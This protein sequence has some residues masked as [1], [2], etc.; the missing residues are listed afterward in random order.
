MQTAQT[1]Q[2]E[3]T[4]QTKETNGAIY[5]RG[6]AQP[7]ALQDQNAAIFAQNWHEQDNRCTKKTNGQSR[8]ASKWPPLVTPWLQL[9]NILKV[10]STCR[11]FVI[12]TVNLFHFYQR[13]QMKQMDQIWKDTTGKLPQKDPNEPIWL[14][15]PQM[16]YKRAK[17]KVTQ[18]DCDN[19]PYK[20]DNWYNR[21]SPSYCL[22]GQWSPI[23]QSSPSTQLC[24]ASQAHTLAESILKFATKRLTHGLVKLI[25]KFATN[26]WPTLAELILKF[27]MT[28]MRDSI[29][30]P[31]QGIIFIFCVVSLLSFIKS[32][33]CSINKKNLG[34]NER[35]NFCLQNKEI[36]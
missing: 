36:F 26:T 27:A 17:W 10:W 33:L 32:L 24:N 6:A 9:K 13:W 28:E 23:V 22:E 12:P 25:L 1:N 29:P 4:K 30:I 14:V 7:G 8:I 16:V 11:S 5:T 19:K 35:T 18:C 31:H 3:Q 34:P 21:N 2:R 20:R 15:E